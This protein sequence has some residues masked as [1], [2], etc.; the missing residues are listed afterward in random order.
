[1]FYSPK[2]IIALDDYHELA[3]SKLVSELDTNI[4]RLK[5]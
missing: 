5:F 2:I 1:M 4:C 3:L